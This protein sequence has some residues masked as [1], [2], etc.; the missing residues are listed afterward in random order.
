AERD[1][2]H[3]AARG[4]EPHQGP[5]VRGRRDQGQRRFRHA[6]GGRQAG[7]HR[8]Q[9]RQLTMVAT[10]ASSRPRFRTD[11]VA[12]PIDEEGQRFID[13]I[14]PDTGNAFRFYEVEYSIACAM[15]GERAVGGLAAWAREE[16]G[17][18]PSA[19]ELRA[20]I[21]TLGDLGYLEGAAAGAPM[22]GEEIVQKGVVVPPPAAPRAPDVELGAG[23]RVADIW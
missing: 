12:E 15:D 21:S 3:R 1:A 10:A 19:D 16:L 5:G 22:F 8:A 18:S 20:V 9:E 6:Q 23:G 11:L 4:L 2:A 7:A 17:I 14:D 13:V